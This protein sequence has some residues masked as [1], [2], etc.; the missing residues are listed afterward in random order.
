M[1]TVP[2]NK[3]PSMLEQIIDEVNALNEGEQKLLL[4]KLKKEEL[5]KKYKSLDEELKEG[6][7][8]VNE[9]EIP[10]IISRNRKDSYD[11]KI[12]S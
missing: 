11:K 7:L 9:D 5:M 4:L 8:L 12:H 1:Q 10:L 3:V 2:S 6:E